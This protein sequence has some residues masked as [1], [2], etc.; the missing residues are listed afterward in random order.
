MPFV[1]QSSDDPIFV[2]QIVGLVDRLSTCSGSVQGPLLLSASGGADGRQRYA[3]SSE[4]FGLYPGLKSIGSWGPPEP[5]DRSRWEVRVARGLIAT[6]ASIVPPPPSERSLAR[7]DG[8]GGAPLASDDDG[9]DVLPVPRVGEPPA[10][11]ASDG[12]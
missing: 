3:L 7:W 12:R 8:E 2:D 11:E 5:G 9:A 10:A 4:L 1:Y 6:G